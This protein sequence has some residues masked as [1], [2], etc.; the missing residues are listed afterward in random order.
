MKITAAVV[1]GVNQPYQLETLQLAPPG[2]D[3]VLVKIVATG[4]CH[5]DDAM[6]MGANPYPF[7]GVFGHEGAGIVEQVGRSVRQVTV[8]DHVVLAYAFCGHCN[9]CLRGAP[10]K[11]VAW[12][13]LNQNTVRRDGRAFFTKSDGTPCSNFFYQSSFATHTVVTESNITK[14]DA[15]ADLRL[16]GPLGCGFQTGYGTVLNGL[17]PQAGSS[18]AIF[19]T[20]AVG[21][22]AMM[23]AKLAGCTQII[24]IDIHPSR[25]EIARA[26]GAT[27][28]VNSQTQDAGKAIAALTHN[29]GVNFA[30]DTS[31]QSA[32]MKLALEVLAI[33]GVLAPVAVTGRHSLEINPFRDLV[34]ANKKM[35]GVLMGNTVPQIAIP[36]L[37]AAHRDGRFPYDSLITF[38]DFADINQASA[39][40]LSGKTIKPVLI[41]D[42]DYRP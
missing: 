18:I 15:S 7:P 16:L 24:A 31:G 33:D 19:G 6:R 32:V 34:V 42:K 13:A 27:D 39:D 3:E 29:K 9:H 40:S 21:L 2:D 23:A 38:Y 14:V 20:G 36:E 28:A 35:V 41:I 26:L 10:A 22:A 30:I 5:S 12:P 1:N 11:C 17:K 37:I 25:L 4:I 8:G